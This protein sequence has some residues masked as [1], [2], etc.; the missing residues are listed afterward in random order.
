[1]T[2]L[3]K[4]I[5]EAEIICKKKGGRFTLKRKRILLKL[6]SKNKALSPYEIA[7]DYNVDYESKMP[8]MSIYRI[9][10]F[11][12]KMNLVHK[13]NAINKYMACSHITCSHKHKSPQF[14]ICRN[15]SNIK[16]V[17]L[18]DKL[19]EDLHLEAKKYGF[20]LHKTYSEISCLCNK[21]RRSVKIMP[22]ARK[23]DF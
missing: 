14:L 13:I 18:E 6:L 8:V 23:L 1:M 3:D 19:V 4:V 17:Y 16:E 11:L 9:L 2:D 5:E 10:D 12:E 21:C 15:C 22:Q 7:D 20:Q